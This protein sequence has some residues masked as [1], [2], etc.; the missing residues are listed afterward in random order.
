MMDGTAGPIRL[1]IAV[2][3]ATALL[4]ACA[5]PK[6]PDHLEIEVNGY[7]ENPVA[8]KLGPIKTT[9]QDRFKGRNDIKFELAGHSFTG[10]MQTIDESVT[11]TGQSTSATKS[12]GV[13]VVGS[14]TVAAVSGTKK[15]TA[16]SSTTTSAS[17]NGVASA[18]SN[19]GLTM[20]C[21]YVV[22][23][24]Q[25]TATGTCDLS[26]GAKYRFFGK[27]VKMVYSDGT[28]RDM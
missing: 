8:A 21:E 3:A 6:R 14:S 24:K 19:K 17:S 22:N 15:Q 27:P 10:E 18:F 16:S 23:N 25:F 2:A 12:A 1:A 5:V 28:S 9:V 20:K 11:T 26:N 7:P 4:A 13:G